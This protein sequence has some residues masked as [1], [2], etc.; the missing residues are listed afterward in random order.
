MELEACAIY[1]VEPLNPRR[2]KD[3]GRVGRLTSWD[4]QAKT[5]TMAWTDGGTGAVT[6]AD[7]VREV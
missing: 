6:L 7:L 1:R 5:G 3:R 4:D 2:R